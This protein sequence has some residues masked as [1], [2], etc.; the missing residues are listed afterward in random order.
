MLAVEFVKIAVI[1]RVMFRPVPPVPVAA[2]GNQYLLESELALRL[3]RTRG[4]LRVELARVINVVP[5]AIVLR[6]TDPHIKVRVDPRPGHERTQL[7][8]IFVAR[9]RLGGR[10]CLHSRLALQAIVKTP[11]EFAPRL[12]VAL[13]CTL[14]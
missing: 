3:G 5:G 8:E 11:Q 13:P 1:G 12:W 10:H 7:A 2:L 9:N 14:P 6:S 4:I